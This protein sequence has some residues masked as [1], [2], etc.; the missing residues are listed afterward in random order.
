MKFEEMKTLSE[1][2]LIDHINDWKKEL[3]KISVAK[4]REKKAAKPHMF[5]ELKK[6]VARANTLIR[7]KKSEE[8]S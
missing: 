7:Q 4:D 1:E 6:R 3:F 8:V 5:T 2:K